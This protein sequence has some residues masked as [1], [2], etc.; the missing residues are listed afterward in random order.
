MRK[1]GGNEWQVLAKTVCIQIGR[2]TTSIK[3]HN[4]AGSDYEA[5]TITVTF[6]PKNEAV[7]NICRSVKIIDDEIS[8]EPDE[9]LSF[10]LT[11]ATPEGNL[12]E[13]IACI[14]IIDNDEGML[15]R[16]GEYSAKCYDHNCSIALLLWLCVWLSTGL[17]LV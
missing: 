9:Q 7:Q 4:A 15:D 1:E 12:G 2:L 6:E 3:F 13:D 11:S 8:N 16:E 17:V 14:T 5:T 10:R